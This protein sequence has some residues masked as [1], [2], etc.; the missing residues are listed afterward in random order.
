M[1]T[2]RKELL[3]A[4]QKAAADS[5]TLATQLEVH[6]AKA[7]TFESLGIGANHFDEYSQRFDAARNDYENLARVPLEP[8][9]T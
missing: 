4:A 5:L 3:Q 7:A 1:I 2:N 6:K 9:K 8:P